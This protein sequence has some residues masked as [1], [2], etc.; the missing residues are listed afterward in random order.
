MG[1]G[2]PCGRPGAG[3]AGGGTPRRVSP[4]GCGRGV[5]AA[6]GRRHEGRATGSRSPRPDSR[7]PAP[8]GPAAG[9][10]GERWRRRRPSAESLR[11]RSQRPGGLGREVGTWQRLKRAE[12]GRRPGGGAAGR[13]RRAGRAPP[14]EVLETPGAARVQV[15]AQCLP[16]PGPPRAPRRGAG[17]RAGGA[18]PCVPSPRARGSRGRGAF[19][20]QPRA[21]RPVPTP[22]W[23]PAR[24]PRLL[25]GLGAVRSA[26]PSCCPSA[27][28]GGAGAAAA[29]RCQAP[30]EGAAWP[31]LPE[32][33]PRGAASRW[34][35]PR[36]SLQRAKAG[37]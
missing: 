6:G 14:Q 23:V 5:R 36:S 12:P 34:R 32:V 28:A 3:E 16:G 26:R 30:R 13:R 9:P 15:R 20:A 17:A 27:A 1:L 22:V 35:E 18:G 31:R 8:R 2:P 33:G 10:R 21:L 7:L 29:R 24:R 25:P 19:P 11:A 4:E 37:A